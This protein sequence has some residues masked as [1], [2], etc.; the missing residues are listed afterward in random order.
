MMK[1]TSLMICLLIFMMIPLSDAAASGGYEES[2]FKASTA[3]LRDLK[4]LE[5]LAGKRLSVLGFRDM[6]TGEGCTALSMALANQI[7]SNLNRIRGL[8]DMNFK[9]TPRH[10]LA[11]IETEYLIS[12]RGGGGDI[13]DRLSAADIL[14]TGMWQDQGKDLNLT[15]KAVPIR[16]VDIDQL[17][18]V[19]VRMD[20]ANIPKKLLLCLEDTQVSVEHF[21]TG[22]VDWDR[23]VIRVKGWGAA[24]K[25]FP[26]PVWKKSAEEAAIVDAQT[27]LVELVAGLNIKSKVFIKNYQVSSDEKVKEVKGRLRHARKVGKTVYPSEDIAE[28]VF[29]LNL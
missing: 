23:K 11:S 18:S 12:K 24:N 4:S 26:K 29:E 20:K 27:K 2:L 7:D 8:L 25:S 10:A 9:T 28:V 17:T 19:S 21:Q 16:D 1:K 5:E 6:D 22:T 3:I 13:L 14:I 15:I